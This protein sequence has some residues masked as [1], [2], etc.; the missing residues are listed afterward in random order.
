MARKD[1]VACRRHLVCLIFGG[2]NCC[3]TM[4]CANVLLLLVVIS[5]IEDVVGNTEGPPR[6][7]GIQ[8]RI[9]T[10]EFISESAVPIVG[11]QQQDSGQFQFADLPTS[12]GT[13]S[14][15]IE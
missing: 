6:H 9:L 10:G 1:M 2:S 12:L 4:G 7:L 8:P 3:G 11:R 5:N 13:V 15:T 14:G